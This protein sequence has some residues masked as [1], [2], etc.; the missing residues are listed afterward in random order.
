MDLC[1][2]NLINQ[3]ALK[4]FCLDVLGIFLANYFQYI[5]IASLLFFLA[6]NFKKYWKIIFLAL[7]AGAFARAFIEI[8]YFIYPTI[9][10]FGTIDVNQLIYHSINNS[11][12]SGHATLFF[13]LATIIFLY[14]KK[15]GS[16]YFLAA[17]LISLARVFCGIHWPS[18]ILGGAVSGVLI[19]LAINYI[20]STMERNKLVKQI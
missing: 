2:F 12:P 10:P 4:W 3:F 5:V 13:A 8:I 16:L 17:L 6:I 19:A 18:D 7:F 1:L 14:N 20:F 9:R 11:F 15:T